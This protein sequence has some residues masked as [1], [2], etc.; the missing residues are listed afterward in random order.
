MIKKADANGVVETRVC[1]H[2]NGTVNV[3]TVWCGR[4]E[5]DV[6]PTISGDY[7]AQCV[8]CKKWYEIFNVEK[9]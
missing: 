3:K 5:D 9:E 7:V 4:K 8:K 6:K 2:C 1:R